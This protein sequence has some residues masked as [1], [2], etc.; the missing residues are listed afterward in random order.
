MLIHNFIRGVRWFT[1]EFVQVV[2]PLFAD[3]E[4]MQGPAN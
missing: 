2:Y 3:I 1:K 4:C